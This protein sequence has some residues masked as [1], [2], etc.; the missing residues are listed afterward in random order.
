V[1]SL[2][3]ANTDIEKYCQDHFGFKLPSQLI[4]NCTEKL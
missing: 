2:K 1:K 4:T 3:T